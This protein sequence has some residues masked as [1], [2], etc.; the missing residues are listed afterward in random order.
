MAVI[1]I[2]TLS[3]TYAGAE[4]KALDTL[5]L[6][7]ESGEFV[8][9]CGPSG[10]G[11]STLLRLLKPMIAPKGAISGTI[12][13][14]D[15]PLT[16]LDRYAQAS[17]IGY[18]GQSPENQ[19]VTDKVWHE[20]AFGLEGLGYSSNEIRRRTAEISD[21]FG[22]GKLFHNDTASLSGGQKQLLNLASVMVLEPKILIL[23]EP[24]SQLD[25]IAASEFLSALK[26][27]N[28]ELGVIVILTEHRLDEA[29]PLSTKT[30]FM[31]NGTVRFV[32]DSRETGAFL[33]SSNSRMFSAMPA[34]MR[35]WAAVENSSDCPITVAEGRKWLEEFLSSHTIGDVPQ[36]DLPRPSNETVLTVTETWF[37]YERKLPDIIKGLSL[38]VKKGEILAILGGNGSGKTTL[39]RLLCGIRTPYRGKLNVTTSISA[40][41]QDP[42]S[43]FVKK[44]VVEELYDAFSDSGISAEMQHEKIRHVT[45]LCRLGELLHQHP[46]DLS[47]GEMQRLGLAKILLKDSDILLLDEPT[48]GF[49]S[50]FKQLFGS[51]LTKLTKLGKTVVMVSH[52]VEFCAEYAHRC[53]LFFDG[54]IIS[55]GNPAEFF[56]GNSF[57]TTSANRMSRGIIKN[58]ITVNDVISACGGTV[59]E[60]P[61]KDIHGEK[62]TK[63]DPEVPSK[64][65]PLWRK[66]IGCISGISSLLLLIYTLKITDISAAIAS[67]ELTSVG[68][69]QLW[70]SVLMIISLLVFGASTAQKRSRNI[71][72]AF[73]RKKLPKKTKA[74][75]IISVLLAPITLIIGFKIL[76]IRQ[77]YVVSTIVLIECMLPFFM[78]FEGR[79]P[80]ARELVVIASLCA[81][82]IAGRAAFIMLPQ[83]KP[84]AAL[85]IIT[86]IALGGECGFLVG[87]VTMLT[88]N[89]LFSQGPW[90]PFQMFAMGMIG[91]IPGIIFHRR[92]RHPS[93]VTL[94]IFGAL[95]VIIV[96]GGIMNP[97]SAAVIGG[98][99]LTRELIITSY[100]AGFPMDLVHAFATALFLW[101]GSEPM[102]EKL[103]RIKVKYD[104]YS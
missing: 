92:S 30:V 41:P 80:R 83:F 48:K 91:F 89:I 32:G 86:G 44:T 3:F 90:T 45:E 4:K 85:T 11:K 88:S 103:D 61:D 101:F 23:D 9:I 53:A 35:I 8:V 6:E 7:I 67:S 40:L 46:Y 42:Q 14:N 81:L 58:A 77:Y 20:L 95:S 21:F 68:Y 31:E 37:R 63:P 71:Y 18:V 104:L 22:I 29:I 36:R 93:R 1:N 38:T 5:S 34:P 51:I 50:E 98:K 27:I 19:I 79:K 13:F 75:C 94:C 96:Y 12:I 56:G 97:V 54:Y 99:S 52:D 43:L 73:V 47:G 70:C 49:D 60:Q 59:P 62:Y 100:I 2:E 33:R 102:L 10:C 39:L 78:S 72:E 16:S 74:A 69:R 25:P 82:C 84:V 17:M 24:T 64:K 76:D 57:Y 28:S 66:I 87:S 55:D 26:K 65:L 15:T